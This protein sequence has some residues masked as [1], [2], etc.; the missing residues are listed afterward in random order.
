MINAEIIEGVTY[1]SATVRGVN[2]SAYLTCF[3]SWCVHTSRAALGRKNVGSYKY[4][5]TVAEVAS[6]VKA[7][8][9]LDVLLAA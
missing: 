7:F 5:D 9:G 6:G 1:Y 4:F 8:A 3:G 2:Y